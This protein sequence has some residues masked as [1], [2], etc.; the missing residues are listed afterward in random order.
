MTD[1]STY[2]LSNDLST[3]LTNT[4]I[5]PTIPRNFALPADK[6]ARQDVSSISLNDVDNARSLLRSSLL[7]IEF[8]LVL[9]KSL[10]VLDADMDLF[11][12]SYALYYYIH[13]LVRDR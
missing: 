1:R 6:I 8:I 7:N 4:S 3:D 2:S 10:G 9:L 5:D 11:E 13:L 12:N